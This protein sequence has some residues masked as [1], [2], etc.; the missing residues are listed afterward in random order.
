MLVFKD[1]F[2]NNYKYIMKGKNFDRKL[3]RVIE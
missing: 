2:G 3:E 1:S